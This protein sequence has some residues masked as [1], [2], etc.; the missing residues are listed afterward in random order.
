MSIREAY[1]FTNSVFSNLC[2]IIAI[3]TSGAVDDF[4]IVNVDLP[5]MVIVPNILTLNLSAFTVVLGLVPFLH[6]NLIV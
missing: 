2:F 3:A 5:L 4:V 6:K 1:Y